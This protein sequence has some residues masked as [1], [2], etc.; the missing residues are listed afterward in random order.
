M[1]SPFYEN[2]TITIL[3]AREIIKNTPL[4]YAILSTKKNYFYKE[5]CS[6]TSKIIK[7]PINLNI[8]RNSSKLFSKT[9]FK[10]K[11]ISICNTE[12]K[13]YYEKYG[14]G[15]IRLFH[16]NNKY[17]IYKNIIKTIIKELWCPYIFDKFKT[18]FKEWTY[19]PGNPG[20]NRINNRFNCYSTIINFI[21][22]KNIL[23][24]NNSNINNLNLDNSKLNNSKLN[25]VKFTFSKSF[26]ELKN[27]LKN[28]NKLHY[29]R[30]NNLDYD[31]DWS[32]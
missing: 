26:L 27:K 32:E 18:K 31:S 16:H 2:V 9:N 23:K 14:F 19:T 7:I 21:N 11:I 8:I 20:Y 12:I 5:D 25:N 15:S 28:N 24:L 17:I 6:I 22:N 4:I 29:K 13:N 3:E 1:E 30:D 10:D